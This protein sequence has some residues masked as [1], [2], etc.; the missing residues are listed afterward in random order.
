MSSINVTHHVFYYIN[1][2]IN[3]LH[4]SLIFTRETCTIIFSLEMIGKTESQCKSKKKN[5]SG[6]EQNGGTSD[7]N[8][9]NDDDEVESEQ[10]SA[11]HRAKQIKNKC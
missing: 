6:R 5:D 1:V 7:D 10:V 9:N 8:D 2:T 11:L 4:T 3:K